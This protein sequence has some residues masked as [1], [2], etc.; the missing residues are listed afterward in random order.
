M[1][2]DSYQTVLREILDKGITELRKNFNAS[3]PNDPLNSI[4]RDFRCCE[5]NTSIPDS[6]YPSKPTG[7]PTPI[8]AATTKAPTKAPSTAPPAAS[9][10]A[11]T[12]NATVAPAAA[13][14]PASGRRKREAGD[15]KAIHQEM[16]RCGHGKAQRRAG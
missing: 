4:Q 1:G 7:A 12:A 6:C 14:T 9:T 15:A 2:A 5:F 10:A 16:R 11:P 13:T 3:D 8:P